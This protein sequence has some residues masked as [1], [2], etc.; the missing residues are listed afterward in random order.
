MA[1]DEYERGSR[2]KRKKQAI[3]QIAEA[4]VTEQRVFYLPSFDWVD[5]I[6]RQGAP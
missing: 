1:I 3:G 5:K 4:L 6:Q 2:K